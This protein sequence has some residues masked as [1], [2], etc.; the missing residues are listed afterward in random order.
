MPEEL[1]RK[2]EKP[3][4]YELLFALTPQYAGKVIFVKKG[5]RLSLQYHKEKDESMYLLG[6]KALF[7]VQVPN[8]KS[9][10]TVAEPGYCL[11][12]PTMTIHLVEALEDA[13][14]IE[15]S[16]PQLSDVVRMQDDYGRVK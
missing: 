2:T 3:W 9:M 10:E 7:T 5:Y 1:P 12:L 16:T 11:H 14:I 6:G 15:V 13:T 8:R 4:G